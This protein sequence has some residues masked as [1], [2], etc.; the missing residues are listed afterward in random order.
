MKCD[1]PQSI[2]NTPD[3]NKNIS[4][5]TSP[6]AGAEYFSKKLDDEITRI[7]EVCRKWNTYRE[8]NTVP[9]EA[10][11]MINVAVGQS[12]LLISKKFQQFRS[13]I[14]QCRSNEYV[15]KPISCKDLHG[16]WDMMYMQVEDLNKRF[17][18]LDNLRANNWEEVLPEKKTVV[19]RGRGRPK[20]TSGSSS[21]KNFMKAAR[22][23]KKLNKD[24]DKDTNQF[25]D[26]ECNDT[27]VFSGGYYSIKSPV[28][29]SNIALQSP[30]AHP[31]SGRRSL[32]VSLLAHQVKNRISSPGLTMMK[33]SQAIK[34][35]DGLTPGKSILKNDLTK[36]ATK[37]IKSV[38]FKDDLEEDIENSLVKAQSSSEMD[39]NKENDLN[40]VNMITFS[41]CTLTRRSRRLSK[42]K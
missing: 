26:L 12:K 17:N 42:L 2:P 19:K 18:N 22:E 33:V 28:S 1:I 40:E 30:A 25:L 8:E 41:P 34:R 14:E 11:D 35:G 39:M 16:F 21:L 37:M 31:N 27:K 23:K 4:S 13:L 9:E 7:E 5:N 20:K 32:R 36:S 29:T 3:F 15:E 38:L 6:K 10:N 24:T